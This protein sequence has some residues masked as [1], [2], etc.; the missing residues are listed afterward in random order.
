MWINYFLQVFFAITVKRRKKIF[1]TFY[2]KNLNPGG[3]WG[4]G[5]WAKSGDYK[6]KKRCT[7]SEDKW[8]VESKPCSCT[9][10]S[11]TALIWATEATE[12]A[13][14]FRACTTRGGYR[15]LVVAGVRRAETAGATGTHVS[16]SPEILPSLRRRTDLQFNKSQCHLFSSYTFS[17]HR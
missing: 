14:L 13:W 16:P 4:K 6:R 15:S 12:S 9:S 8:Q 11:V 10:T 5:R 1:F 3:W 17:W 7:P 2:F